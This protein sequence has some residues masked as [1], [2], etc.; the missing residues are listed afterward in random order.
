MAHLCQQ[1]TRRAFSRSYG[2]GRYDPS[3]EWGG[4]DYPI[5][6]V[7]WTEQ[8]NFQACLHLLGTGELDLGAI[9]TQRVKFDDSLPVYEALGD[10]SSSDVGVV[11]EYGEPDDAPGQPALKPTRRGK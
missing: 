5:G 4:A 3:Y 1:G 9:T 8:R 11:M 7:R 2:P 6:Y 10:G